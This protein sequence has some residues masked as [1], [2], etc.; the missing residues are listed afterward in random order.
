[1][2]FAQKFFETAALRQAIYYK[3]EVLRE[4]YPW[5]SDERFN[6]EFFCNVFRWQDKTTKV[7]F[8]KAKSIEELIVYRCLSRIETI[9]YLDKH[10][11]GES[12]DSLNTLLAA[13]ALRHP[14]MTNAFFVWPKPGK[15]RYEIP[16]LI[17]AA[18]D[19]DKIS[20]AKTMQEVFTY[21]RSLPATGPFMAYE[22]ATDFSYLVKYPDE[23]SW[24]S[25]GLGARRGMSRVLTGDAFAAKDEDYQAFSLT[26]YEAWTRFDHAKELRKYLAPQDAELAARPFYERLT[27]REVEHWLCEYDKYRRDGRT[28][29]QYYVTE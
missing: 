13:Y 4:P 23:T 1:M 3:K 7:I 6:T 12:L 15:R 28:K 27:M 19:P 14:V 16:G 5:S 21:C 11:N 29:R 17:F 9:E 18:L 24:S 10:W 8:D 2:Q 25:C 26:L 20:K 22:Y